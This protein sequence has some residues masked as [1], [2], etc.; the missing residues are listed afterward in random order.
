MRDLIN[1]V[2]N[3]TEWKSK[4]LYHVSP[5]DKLQSILTH[6]LDPQ[7]SRGTKAIYLASDASHALGYS[8]HH[9]Q[10]DSTLLIISIASLDKSLLLPDDADF[11]DCLDDPYS[12]E[13]YSWV[14][15]LHI[16]G[17]CRY[18][19]IIPASAIKVQ[20]ASTNA[21]ITEDRMSLDVAAQHLEKNGYE[22]LGAGSYG[23]VLQKPGV[24]YVLKLFGANDLAYISFIELARKNEANPHFPRFYGK[25]VKVTNDY[26][27][28]RMEPL[29]RYRYDS[30]LIYVYMRDRNYYRDN[31]P[32]D[33]FYDAMELMEEY[34]LL[35]QACDIILDNLQNFKIDIRNDNLM[36]RGKT[37]VIT[38]PI[39]IDIHA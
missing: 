7:F 25:L 38:D 10:N 5:R 37:I 1:L 23:T 4:F 11:P 31:E 9:D 26:Y 18:E 6:G 3:S 32:S 12:F 24:P 36:L 20:I 29:D 30:T 16:S 15:S 34:P 13:N 22:F 35:Q 39:K 21:Y 8:N 27:A 28:I 33:Q 14:D 17:Q 19:G 2:E